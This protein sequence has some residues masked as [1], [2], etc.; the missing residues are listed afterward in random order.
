[1]LHVIF[2]SQGW[3]LLS[4]YTQIQPNISSVSV[5]GNFID[6]PTQA[7]YAKAGNVSKHSR[8]DK[9]RASKIKHN[10]LILLIF[11][12]LKI[13][14]SHTDKSQEKRPRNS[15][16]WDMK[17]SFKFTC[18]FTLRYNY[19]SQY[20]HRNQSHHCHYLCLLNHFHSH[21]K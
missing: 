14:I 6:W 8:V 15:F 12:K 19:L 7:G 11:P 2:R 17:T 9:S 20:P 13:T 16:L 5:A 3:I 10:I 18:D 1:M 4:P 21:N